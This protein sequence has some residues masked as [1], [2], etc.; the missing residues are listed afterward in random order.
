MAVNEASNKLQE[1]MCS[2]FAELD[3]IYARLSALIQPPS[4]GNEAA[5]HARIAEERRRAS[6]IIQRLRNIH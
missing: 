3:E 6:D 4:Y 1:E 5:T 2:L